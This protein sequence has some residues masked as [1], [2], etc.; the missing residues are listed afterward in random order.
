M[1]NNNNNNNNKFICPSRNKI[2]TKIKHAFIHAVILC[3]ALSSV[4]SAGLL[5]YTT[6]NKTKQKRQQKKFF[7]N[8]KKKNLTLLHLTN[9][10]SSVT[11]ATIR[12]TILAKIINK[13][14]QI[15]HNLNLIFFYL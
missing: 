10:F 11:S 4:C 15:L 13:N 12:Y 8:L 2:F 3:R 14:A 7:L 1:Q 9:E 6:Q 5:G